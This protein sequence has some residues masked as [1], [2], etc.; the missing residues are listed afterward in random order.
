METLLC[1]GILGLSKKPASERGSSADSC[2]DMYSPLR[3]TLLLLAGILALGF[4]HESAFGQDDFSKAL[5]SDGI[6]WESNPVDAW[7]AI[8]DRSAKVGGESVAFFGGG[9]NGDYRGTLTTTLQGP[10]TVSFW[11]KAM[12]GDSDDEPDFAIDGTSMLR[13]E[14]DSD[15]VWEQVHVGLPDGAH[16]LSFRVFFREFFVDGFEVRMGEVLPVAEA[17][18][19]SGGIWAQEG[20]PWEI[21]EGGGPTGAAS[22]VSTF[23]DDPSSSGAF[24][25]LVRVPR[26]RW[27]FD[28]PLLVATIGRWVVQLPGNWCPHSVGRLGTKECNQ[29]RPGN[30]CF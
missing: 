15:P 13:R 3:I 29:G 21:V 20:E 17:L 10:A 22:I 18:G 28:T 16:E 12:V 9:E 23:G 27:P 7:R 24:A 5:D 8:E 6:V 30:P 2:L 11:W 25:K 19:D 1:L 4:F 26:Q 14:E